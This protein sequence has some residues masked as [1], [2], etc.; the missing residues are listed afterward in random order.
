[1]KMTK[2]LLGA[3]L[4]FAV[5][6]TGCA[7]SYDRTD[8]TDVSQSDMPGTV[9]LNTVRVTEGS[10]L[11]AHVI[12]YNSDGNPL[13]GEVRSQN[14][15]VLDCT[16]AIGNKWAFLGVSKG[17]TTVELVADGEVVGRITAEVTA[18]P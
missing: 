14:P 1:M 9:S 3:A 16:R 5:A 13:N 17:T 12:P 10:L 8:I 15:K 11:T 7:A 6:S 2:H 4:A 18:Q